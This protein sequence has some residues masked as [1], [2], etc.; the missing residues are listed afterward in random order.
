M[1]SYDT[2]DLVELAM[3]KRGVEQGGRLVMVTFSLT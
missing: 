3:E 1:S 2:T